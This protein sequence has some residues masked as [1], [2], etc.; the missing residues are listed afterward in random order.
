MRI[1][2]LF[3]I[4]SILC[5]PA[6]AVLPEV[7]LSGSLQVNAPSGDFAKKNLLNNQGGAKLGTGGEIDLGLSAD[8]GSAYIGYR[9]GQLDAKTD[10]T[11]AIREK[12]DN[13]KL[14]R[15]VIGVRWHILG[16]KPL[17][18]V[19]TL[20]GGLTFGTPK[21]SLENA[22]TKASSTTSA[23]S[24]LGWFIEAG[25]LLRPPGPLSVIANIQYHSY[26]SKFDS[27]N[28]NGT[29]KIAYVTIQAGVRYAFTVL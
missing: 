5:V 18:I 8:I 12:A 1:C 27:A 24:S 15:A 20:G 16:S 29:F 22:L 21:L 10:T 11:S 19:P 17:P 2:T 25:A 7:Y 28:M 23:K 14:D 9:F 26:D 4:L 6:F 3:L 13:W